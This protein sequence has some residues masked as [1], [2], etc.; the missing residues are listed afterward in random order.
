VDGPDAAPFPLQVL[1]NQTPVTV[2]RSG[3]AAQQHRRNV[4]DVPVQRL[5]DPALLQEFEECSLVVRPSP[6]FPVGVEDLTRRGESGLAEVLSAAELLQ[7]ERE[8]GSSGETR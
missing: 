6:A 5:L 4:E 1:Q 7:E 8:V 3:L 2:L